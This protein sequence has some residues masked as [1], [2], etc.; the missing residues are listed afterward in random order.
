[1]KNVHRIIGKQVAK[2]ITQRE[3]RREHGTDREVATSLEAIVFTDGS[4]LV[5]HA[6]EGDYEPYTRASYVPASRSK[7]TKELRQ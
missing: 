5:L 1:M 4:V 7:Y 6:T 2:L 3:Q